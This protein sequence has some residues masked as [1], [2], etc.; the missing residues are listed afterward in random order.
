MTVPGDEPPAYP[1]GRECPYR[2]SHRNTALRERGPVAPV[3]LYDGRVVWLVTGYAESRALLADRRV[4][5]DPH[6]A[7]FPVLSADMAGLED[8]GYTDVLIGV[9]PPVHTRQRAMLISSFAKRRI[10]EL[11][12]AL[13]RIVDDRLD[14]M[15]ARPD[16][17]A[18]LV[19]AF[20][21]PVPAMAIC[22]L[23]GVPY[24][25]REA[26]EKP[27]RALFDPD[28]ERA[29]AAV[30][31][32]TAYFGD[33]VDQKTARP[34]E[35]L[36]DDLIAD[37]AFPVEL[38]RDDLVQYAMLML[39]AGQDTTANVI[40]LGMM[41]LLRHP[42]QFAALR[43]NPALVPGAVE[44]I[45]RYVSLIECISR[46]ALADIEIGGQRIAAGDGILI[47]AGAANFSTELLDRPEEFDVRRGNRRHLGFG[48]GIHQCIG[49]NLA[50]LELELAFGGIV[51][52]MPGLRLA[53]PESEVPTSVTGPLERVEC[54]PVTW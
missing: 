8:T 20:A 42:A 18:D 9:D 48:H 10:D 39:I 24:E 2:P 32:M 27:A 12:P 50:R 46:A 6:H 49:Q 51:R 29:E 15:L 23:M 14:E 38:G 5:I 1:I 37:P 44:E 25:D 45:M 41:A 21:L 35:G 3:R 13:E 11:R 31:A 7:N 30:A 52:R 47:G 28:P 36:L 26:F 43:D 34:G 40:S 4:S 19:S 22:M 33:L 53:V 54:L 16:R 17:T